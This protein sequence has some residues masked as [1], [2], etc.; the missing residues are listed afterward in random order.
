[1][2]LLFEQTLLIIFC[3]YLLYASFSSA[4]ES[5]SINSYAIGN[6]TFSSFTL[7]S[8]IIATWISGSGLVLDLMEFQ[9]F[10]ILYFIE[11]LGMCANLALFAWIFIPKMQS[12]LGKT[13]IASYVKKE[14]GEY[15]S[16]LTC[17][18]GAVTSVGGIAIQFKIMG[19]VLCYF[20]GL[21]KDTYFVY[22]VICTSIL[23]IIYTYSG[24]IRNV[25]STDVIQTICFSIALLLA[26]GSFD[27]QC[28]IS[29]NNSD[30]VETTFSQFHLS[31]F[32]TL[33][34]NQIFQ[35][36]FIS[37]YFLIPGFKPHVIQRVSMAKNIEQAKRSYY[38]ASIALVIILMLSCYLSYLI[39]KTNVSL[40]RDEMLSTLINSYSI[41]GTKA[42]LII[43]I[44][45]MC[46]STA[47]SNLN[48]SSVLLAN[49]LFLTKKLN[50]MQ[51]IFLARVLTIVIGLFSII[52]AIKDMSLFSIILLSASFYLPIVSAPVALLILGFKT[53]N[54]ICVWTMVLCLLFVL[55]CNFILKVDF[56]IN[57]IGIVLNIFILISSHYIVEKWELLKCFGITSQLKGEK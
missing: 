30:Y 8:T 28:F 57:F 56:D 20:F 52:F 15:A 23:V 51:K 18:L 53:T 16:N 36:I 7:S 12:L 31:Y 41:P 46:M 11:S 13:S 27:S 5:K 48:I 21:D 33:D 40:S 32:K 24:G 14:Y 34:L 55:L 45:C 47:D 38:Y 35:F 19:E 9:E 17:I 25:A 50:S 2:A 26:I 10:G 49:D 1:M 3:C 39:Y 44:L 6:R 29:L 42:I 22:A 54:R 37:G 43:G 4:R